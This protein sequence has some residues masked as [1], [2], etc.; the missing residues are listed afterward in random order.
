[1][2]IQNG[3]LSESFPIKR[4]CRQ[5]DPPSPDIFLLCAEMLSLLIKQNDYIKSIKIGELELKLSQYADDTK[6]ILD[7]SEQ[8][9]EA[10]LQ[11]LSIFAKISGLKV[12]N[13]KTKA[14]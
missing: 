10:A 4:G 6:I 3:F 13:S 7:G 9:V 8:S 14:V 5:G 2:V 12:N 1:M 11:T